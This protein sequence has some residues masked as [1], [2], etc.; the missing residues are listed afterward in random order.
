MD[1][2]RA[3]WIFTA[4]LRNYQITGYNY[5]FLN[6]SNMPGI[7]LIINCFRINVIPPKEKTALKSQFFNIRMIQIKEA[8]ANF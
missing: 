2:I 4:A 7:I 3:R 1:E 8:F 6:K 5:Y